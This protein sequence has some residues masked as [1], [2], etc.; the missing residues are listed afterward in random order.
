MGAVD[1][2]MYFFRWQADLASG[3][4]FFGLFSGVHDVVGRWVVTRTITRWHEEIVWMSLYFSIAVWT[5]LGL[6][7]FGLLRD[8]LPRYRAGASARLSP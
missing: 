6:G 2:P 7:G 3:R 1:V 4:E 5:S 8:R